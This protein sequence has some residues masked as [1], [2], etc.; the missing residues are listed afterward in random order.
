M[1]MLS[2]TCAMRPSSCMSRWLD[3]S[4]RSVAMSRRRPLMVYCLVSFWLPCGRLDETR[5]S[6]LSSKAFSS[7]SAL[8][9]TSWSRTASIHAW[10]VK[11]CFWKRSTIFVMSLSPIRCIIVSNTSSKACALRLSSLRRGESLLGSYWLCSFLV[12]SLALASCCLSIS[13][14]LIC[15]WMSFCLLSSSLWYFPAISSL[16]SAMVSSLPCPSTFSMPCRRSF[17]C[18]RRALESWL[19]LSRSLRIAS[20]RFSLYEYSWN[21]SSCTLASSLRL[22]SSSPSLWSVSW[23]FSLRRATADII[24]AILPSPLCSLVSISPVTVSSLYSW[25]CCFCLV[26]RTNLT[27]LRIR[28]IL[29]TYSSICASLDSSA[30]RG[31]RSSGALSS[32]VACFFHCSISSSTHRSPCILPPR[33]FFFETSKAMPSCFPYS[34]RRVRFCRISYKILSC[35]ACSSRAACSGIT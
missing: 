2:F 7:S 29:N 3:P 35:V 22:T 19:T 30:G 34:F 14:I 15:F 18:S 25:S 6:C 4:T 23:I 16:I 9:R 31:L 13:L 28:S 20:R 8:T 32:L 21:S 33:L 24:A 26:C 12:S 1:R 10:H 27:S 17:S 11:D 5:C